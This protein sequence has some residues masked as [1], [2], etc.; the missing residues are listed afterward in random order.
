MSVLKITAPAS[1]PLEV[2]TSPPPPCMLNTHPG[3]SGPGLSGAHGFSLGPEES[4]GHAEIPTSLF[5]WTPLCAPHPR[6]HRIK[7]ST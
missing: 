7:G 4:E 3:D 1:V 2:S 6:K 5:L